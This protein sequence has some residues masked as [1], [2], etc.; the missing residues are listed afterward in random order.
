M[1]IK[2]YAV[3]SLIKKSRSYI[4]NTISKITIFQN[5]ETIGI[6]K[7]IPSELVFTCLLLYP[8]VAARTVGILAGYCLKLHVIRPLLHEVKECNVDYYYFR[9]LLLKSKR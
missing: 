5:V 6:T 3:V 9:K 7:L 8:I 2:R 1:Y 4:F